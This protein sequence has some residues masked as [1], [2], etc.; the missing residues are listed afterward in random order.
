[1]ASRR[2]TTSPG[3]IWPAGRKLLAELDAEKARQPQG[4]RGDASTAP[5]PPETFVFFRGNPACRAKA[6]A[7]GRAGVSRRSSIRPPRRSCRRPAG[8]STGR[9]LALAQWI[10]SPDN[11][12]TARVLANRIWQ[13][14]FGR[15]IVRSPSN[16]GLMGDPPTHPELL[17]WLA[18]ELVADGWRL[19]PLHK[20]ILMSRAYRAASTA[21]PPKPWPQIRSTMPSGGSTCG[22][23][24]PRSS[25]TRSM[26]P[27]GPSI[28]RCSGRASIPT[29]PRA[30][31]ATQSLPGQ[32]LGQLAA[33]GAGPPQHLH[34]RQAVAAGAD[35]GRLRPG[36]PRHVLPGAVRHHAADPGPGHDERRLSPRPGPGLRRAGPPRGRRAPTPTRRAAMVRRAIEIAPRAAGHRR[37]GEPRASP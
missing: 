13:H 31:L 24:R 26:W 1:M 11:P 33:R 32:G 12:L 6:G 14:H 21:V 37:G 2:S 30:V 23:C 18:A 27:A 9:R 22:G 7:P 17:D 28:P 8:R 29:C 15:G 3:R 4:A 10:A 34:P 36:R 35:P 19:K 20:T 5:T 16:F 25:A